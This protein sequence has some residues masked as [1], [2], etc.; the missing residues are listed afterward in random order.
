MRLLLRESLRLRSK[1]RPLLRDP[2]R[3]CRLSGLLRGAA[4]APRLCLLGVDH[5]ALDEGFPIVGEVRVL[6]YGRP[7]PRRCG[8]ASKCYNRASA[9]QKLQRGDRLDL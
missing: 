9:A 4:A 7:S 5:V 6:A 2:L 1:T 8:H 3:L